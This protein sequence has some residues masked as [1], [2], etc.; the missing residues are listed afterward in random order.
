MMNAIAVSA[1]TEHELKPGIA[2]WKVDDHGFGVRGA[3]P[4]VQVHLVH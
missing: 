4:R 1:R 3:V 2:V